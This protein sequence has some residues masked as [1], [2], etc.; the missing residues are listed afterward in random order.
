[1]RTYDSKEGT[2]VLACEPSGTVTS[3]VRVYN[4]QKYGLILVPVGD[5]N[6]SSMRVETK[7]G[8]MAVR[9]YP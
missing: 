5:P 6:A 1:M 7:E 2:E 4:G 9:K 3:A 8:T